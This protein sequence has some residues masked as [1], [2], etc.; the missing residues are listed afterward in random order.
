MLKLSTPQL[1]WKVGL[2]P[3]QTPCLSTRSRPSARHV[4]DL[5]PGCNRSQRS[6]PAQQT[7]QLSLTLLLAHERPPQAAARR[8][9]RTDEFRRQSDQAGARR[10]IGA[11]PCSYQ[12]R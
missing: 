4:E 9:V 1:L 11:A 7:V 2:G 6:A 10:A 5:I 12:A 8:L 3:P